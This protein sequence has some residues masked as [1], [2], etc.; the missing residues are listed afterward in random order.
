MRKKTCT[1]RRALQL[2]SAG[3][4]AGLAGC[5]GDGNGDGNGNGNGDGNGNGSGNGTGNGNGT[6]GGGSAA[7]ASVPEGSTMAGYVEVG[8]LLDGSMVRQ[9]VEETISL[10][11]DQNPGYS[12]PGSYE[13]LLS[14]LES[15]MGLDPNGL[16]SMT[17][18]GDVAGMEPAGTILDANWSESDLVDTLSSQGDV[19]L[20]EGSYKSATTYTD[21]MDTG[22]LA[23]LPDGRYVLGETPTVESVVDVVAGDAAAVSG[24]V[25]TA[26]ESSPTGPLRF[27]ADLTTMSGGST[28]PMASIQTLSAGMS[29]GGGQ[30]E[31]VVQMEANDE[32]SARGLKT[33][34][35]RGISDLQSDA[36]DSQ[37]MPPQV[38]DAVD[39]LS[40]IEVQASGTTVSAT[41][42]ADSQEAGVLGTMMAAIVASFVL[43]IGSTQQQSMTP[44]AAFDL[45]YDSSAGTLTITHVSGDTIPGSE[46]YVRGDTGNGRIDNQW[47]ADYGVSEVTAGTSVTVENVSS[48][49]EILVVWEAE[50]GSSSATL[51]QADGPDA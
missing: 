44:S 7:L 9:G 16:N 22:M 4:L 15:E 29:T 12:G 39:E 46:L 14:M 36:G 43:G 2:G 5:S 13:E 27:G 18:F 8:T 30:R 6:G 26:F 35:E 34:I 25:V 20:T 50:G 33:V 42:S 31:M 10:L 1:R 24:R 21:E 45:E 37:D 51:A 48:D 11:R 28:G 3:L 49:Y 32:N 17:V 38:Q 47:G 19:S 41:Y 40:E 23:V